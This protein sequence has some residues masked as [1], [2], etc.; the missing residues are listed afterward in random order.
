MPC[1]R[2]HSLP[3]DTV[4]LFDLNYAHISGLLTAADQLPVGCHEHHATNAPLLPL[5]S[6]YLL[7]LKFCAHL[8]TRTAATDQLPVGYHEHH[9]RGPATHCVPVRE[10]RGTCA[11]WSGTRRW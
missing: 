6:I 7:F 3:L 10:P 11:P 8:L 1:E 9:A 2:L 5:A 4:H